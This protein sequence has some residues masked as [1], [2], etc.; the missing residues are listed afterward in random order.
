LPNSDFNEGFI[1]DSNAF[2]SG[3]PFT[4]SSLICYTTNLVFNEVKHIKRSYSA[5]EALIGVGN[6]IVIDPEEQYLEK[7]IFVAKKTGDYLTLSQADLSI[8]ALA[9]QLQMT[10]IS[11]DYAVENVATFLQIP[12]KTIGTK[13]IAAVRKWIAFCKTCG[14]AYNSST[15]ECLICGNKLKRRFKKI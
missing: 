11:D 10:L 7:I 15:N 1:L 14:R 3:F 13:G 6:L 4:L 5:L 8:L 2:Y 9:F 12:F